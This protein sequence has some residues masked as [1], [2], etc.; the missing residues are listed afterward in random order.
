MTATSNLALPFI[1]AAQAQKHVTH[2][3]ALRIL[4]AAI[5]IAVADRT[6]T[7]PPASP[8]E[9]ERHIVAAGGSGAWAGQCN[10]IASWQD[11]AWAFLAPKQGWCVWSVADDI[12]LVFD[13]SAWRDLR[14]LPLSL[15]NA[16]HLGIG[17]TATAPNLLSVKSNA[18]LIA[19]I[20]AAAGGSGDVRLQLSKESA[21]KTASVVFSDNYSGRA[22]FGLVGTDA[23]KLKVSADGAGW[24]EAFTIDPASGNLAL[25][26]GLALSGVV[27]PPQIGANQNDYAPSG[28]ASAAVLQLS[29]DAARSISGLAGGSEGRVVVLVNVGSQAITLIDDSAASAAANRFA[30]GA[31]VV[32]LARQAVMLRYDATAL[33]WQALAGGA[34]Y[35]VSYGA[36]QSLSAAQQAQARANAGVPNRNY[37]INPSGEVVQSAIG[38]QA[39]ASYDFDQWL[40]LT[41]DAAVSASSLLDAENGTPFMMRSLQAAAAPQRFGRIQWLERLLCRELRGQA[42]VLSARVRS[43]AAITLRYA[44]VEWTGAPDA[45]AK[46]VINDWSNA[47]LTAGH[48]FTAASTLVV[49]TGAT[50]LAANTLTDILPLSGTVSS[51]M[52][53]LAVL[54]WTDTA[55]PQ[56]VTLDI[57]KV[58]LEGG[59]VPTPFVA[60][61]WRDL[62]ADCQRY[63]A[64]T[65]ATGMAPGTP[66]AG[67]GLQHIVE[68][69]SNYAALPT[70]FFPV[71]MRTIPTVTLYS[72]ATGAV[73][74]IYNQSTTSDV[75]G[76]VNGVNS[77]SCS[78]NVNN[79]PVAAMGAL[80]AQVAANARL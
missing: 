3:E 19:A 53:N 59:S 45:I 62:L 50:A 74:Q 65:Y 41:Q 46:D 1:E 47:S 72:Y 73:G 17:T 76:V 68:A 18:A 67:G 29:S 66:W 33:R 78:P 60:Q 12:L 51:S 14:D 23:F 35:A 61:P 25:P 38:S 79:V 77:K 10:A 57:G 69:P 70:W 32:L 16:V 63:Y 28:L 21:A 13:G 42:V 5:Q 27:S 54:F 55:Q 22:E 37:L 7:T 49:G 80:V 34:P 15:D 11:G 71:E 58:K 6:R 30:L 75:S 64:K 31:P 24:I 52:N 2:N 44:I 39:D 43:S 20:T 56:N 8:A 9:G 40:T 4:D 48:F 36:A 26:R